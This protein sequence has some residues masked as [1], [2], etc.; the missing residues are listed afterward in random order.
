MKQYEIARSGTGYG[1][2]QRP[3]NDDAHARQRQA[4]AR[5]G[6]GRSNGANAVLA[7]SPADAGAFSSLV[8]EF[9]FG[10][11]TEKMPVTCLV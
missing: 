5:S 10:A 3:C 8:A 2:S 1:R 7:D 11:G 6:H 9:G 4:G